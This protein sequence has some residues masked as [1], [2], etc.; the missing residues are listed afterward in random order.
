MPRGT[1]NNKMIAIKKDDSVVKKKRRN[2]FV[3]MYATPKE[4]E[5]AVNKYFD[6]LPADEPVTMTGLAL[7]LGFCSRQTV[8]EYSKKPLFSIVAKKAMSRVEHDYEKRLMGRSFPG[9]IF[10]LKNMGW[11]DKTEQTI[12]G[13]L[14]VTRIE[15]PKK[16]NVGDPVEL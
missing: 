15:L 4:F 9:A 12:S 16:C 3:T 6:N 7:A 10:A 5:D 13:G 2:P 8:W 14:Q 11:T 1:P